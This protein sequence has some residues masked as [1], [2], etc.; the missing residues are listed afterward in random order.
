M[1]NFRDNSGRSIGQ[2]VN[3]KATKLL[4]NIKREFVN[5]IHK[6]ASEE[7]NNI[8]NW[9]IS[10]ETLKSDP[11]LLKAPLNSTDSDMRLSVQDA[12]KID[13]AKK[14]ISSNGENIINISVGNISDLIRM[15]AR[16]L[17]FE[18]GTLS[19]SEITQTGNLQKFNI[20]DFDIWT[21]PYTKQSELA[22]SGKI[23]QWGF[24]E[25][26]GGRFG[27][28]YMIPAGRKVEPFQ[29]IRPVRMYRGSLPQIEARVR[30]SFRAVID[31]AK[32]GV[33]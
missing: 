23:S 18:F 32:R 20:S 9:S 25:D 29:G 24:L 28:G 7:V 17:Y 26:S 11:D 13:S 27:L 4:R 6:V 19:H 33:A 8:S 30:T 1:T 3:S 22:A 14:Y 10:Q 15:S 5:E 31:R 12:I 16:T 21:N 2:I